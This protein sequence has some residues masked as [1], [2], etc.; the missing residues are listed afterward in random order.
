[1]PEPTTVSDPVDVLMVEDQEA[2]ASSTVEYL[3]LSGVSAAYVSSAEEAHAA[4]AS[5]KPKLV[6][7]DV[8]LPGLSGFEF[9]RR[10]R[11]ERGDI[12]IVFVSARTGPPE[13][14]VYDDGWLLLDPGSARVRVGGRDVSLAALEFKLLEH[15]VANRGRVVEKRELFRQ[16]WGGAVTG[17]GTLSVHI[18]RLR[19]RIERDP[20]RPRYIRTVWGR[21]YI[22][23]EPA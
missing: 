16:V 6:I 10:L 13:P 15:L 18:R 9:C 8:N 21:G 14:A 4:L 20:D 3:T 1:M 22:F 19:T 11:R 12:P 7:L 2:L 23:E 5:R 17:D